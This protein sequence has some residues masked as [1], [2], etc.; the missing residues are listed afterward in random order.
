[1]V[2]EPLTRHVHFL[3]RLNPEPVFV[4]YLHPPLGT[5]EYFEYVPHLP[6]ECDGEAGRARVGEMK[7]GRSVDSDEHLEG[8]SQL[9]LP[10]LTGHDERHETRLHGHTWVVTGAQRV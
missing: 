7:N 9:H 3:E 4:R 1:M 10:Q 5:S 6:F 2:K 8:E